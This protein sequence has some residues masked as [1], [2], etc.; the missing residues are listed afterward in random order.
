MKSKQS[1]TSL[2]L[3][4]GFFLPAVSWNFDGRQFGANLEVLNETESDERI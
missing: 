1:F 4:T 3:S 2:R